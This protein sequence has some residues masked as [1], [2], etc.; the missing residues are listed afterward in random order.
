MPTLRLSMR[1]VVVG[2]LG[3]SLMLSG[4]ALADPAPKDTGTQAS[5]SAASAPAPSSST[6]H[7]SPA[8]STDA[9]EKRLLDMGYKP[10]MLKGQKVFCKSALETGSRVGGAMHC[11]SVDQLSSQLQLSREAVEQ[12]QRYGTNPQGH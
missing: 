9:R 10:R 8:A 5:P 3:A 12:T 11:G 1:K 2:A 7:S 4:A 6:V